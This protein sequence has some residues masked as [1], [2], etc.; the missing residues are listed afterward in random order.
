MYNEYNGKVDFDSG[1]HV[2]NW[3]NHVGENVKKI[4]DTF[5]EEQKKAIYEDAEYDAS[6]EVWD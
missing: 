2:H 1:G 3:K 4:W 5:T 6:N